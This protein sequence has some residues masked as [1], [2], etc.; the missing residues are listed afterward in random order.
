MASD[1]SSA[2][3][4]RE[5]ERSEPVGPD[6]GPDSPTDLPGSGWK[7]ALRRTVTEFQDDNLTDWAAALTYYGVLSIFP[8]LLV[9]ISILGLLGTSATEGVKDTVNQAVPNDSIRQIIT[10]A[11]TTAD[12][13][14]GLA[15][16]AAIIGVVAA[17]WSASGYIGAFMRASNSIYDVPEGRPIWKTLPIRLGVTAVVGVLLLASA[18]IV[19]FTGRLAETVGDVVGLGSAAVTV[20]DIAKWPVLLLLVS[21]MFAIL[22]WASPNARHGGFRWVSPGGVLA[23]VIWLLISGLFAFYVGNFGSYNK[24]YGALAGVIIFLVW[25]W[26][27]NIAILLGAEFDAELE[28][29]RAISAGH[30]VDDEPYVELRDDRK[31][32]KKRNSAAK[33]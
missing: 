18:V 21:L 15:S 6:A 24:T 4:E 26:L 13:N 10:E 31:L 33:R 2:H 5:P 7:A 30:A 27:S 19:V 14:G 1:E 3:R 22:Y 32:R 25:L 9:L 16:I 12:K 23:V 20:W 28:R 29:G 17:F 8:G 11:I